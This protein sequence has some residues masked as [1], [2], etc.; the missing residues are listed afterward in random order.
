MID[1][2]LRRQH[3]VVNK[4]RHSCLKCTIHKHT[5]LTC[6]EFTR[7]AFSRRQRWAT[8]RRCAACRAGRAS[9]LRGPVQGCSM[10]LNKPCISSVVQLGSEVPQRRRGR[11]TG[12][13]GR[14]SERCV[15][16]DRL[17]RDPV[18]PNAK[19]IKA[20]A[21]SDARVCNRRLQLAWRDEATP[22][23]PSLRPVGS[24][25]RPWP[26][27]LPRASRTGASLES[28]ARAP[29]CQVR[30]VGRLPPSRA[31]RR[32]PMRRHQTVAGCIC[33]AHTFAKY[34]SLTLYFVRQAQVVL[35]LGCVS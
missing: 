25:P 32:R 22:W 13:C 16:Q 5:K 26:A 2:F 6:I 7:A 18:S 23:P 1:G 27:A 35:P 14:V 4:Q 17:Q 28:P 12:R 11:Y 3:F 9:L 24:R 29:P 20:A 34:H 19:E 31:E 15:L 10:R 33:T 21:G 8:A 30:L